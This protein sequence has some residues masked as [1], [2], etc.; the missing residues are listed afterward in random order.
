[1]YGFKDVREYPNISTQLKL[2][3]GTATH[4]LNFVKIT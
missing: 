3:L 1:M 2:R 4:S